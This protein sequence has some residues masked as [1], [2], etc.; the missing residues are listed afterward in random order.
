MITGDVS[1]VDS[2]DLD[3]PLARDIL[4]AQTGVELPESISFKTGRKDSG[5]QVLFR[6]HG[7]GLK[8][9]AGY[10]TDGNGNGVDLKTDGGL[11]VLPPSIHK[12]GKRYEW[13]INP[14]E[15]GLEDLEDFPPEVLSFM[16]KQC[17]PGVGWDQNS[18]RVD[19]DKWFKN[20]NTK[21]QKTTMIYTDMPAKRS[22]RIWHMTKF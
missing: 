11:T 22:I 16:A 7:G 20:R 6:Y 8:T 19:P 15:M 10:V 13:I 5:M 4:N 17:R 18:A 2:I 3:G 21:R 14:I 1:G 9:K 12:S